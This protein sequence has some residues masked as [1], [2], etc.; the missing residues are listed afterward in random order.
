MTNNELKMTANDG[1]ATTGA[2]AA[3]MVGGGIGGLVLGLLTTGSVISEGLK[4]FLTF[5]P[6]VG[7]LSGK[8]AVAIVAWLISWA[9]LNTLWK[10]KDYD[11]DK[12][13]R[14]TLVLTTIGILLTFPP[15]FEAFE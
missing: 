11:L 3:A 9:L 13:F 5:S 8:T 15:I 7:S 10:G 1:A 12:A 2:A 6:A 4:T 14:I